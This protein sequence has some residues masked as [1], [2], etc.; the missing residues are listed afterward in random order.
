[1]LR[2]TCFLL[3]AAV[4]GAAAPITFEKGQP[5]L[6]K[7]SFARELQ[8]A[9][10]RANYEARFMH[11]L[12]GT[13]GGPFPLINVLCIGTFELLGTSDSSILCEPLQENV[14]GFNGYQC[15]MTCSD[16]P[17]CRNVWLN[18]DSLESGPFGEIYFACEGDELAD[19]DAT[20]QYL[21]SEGNSC[22]SNILGDGRNFH[23]RYERKRNCLCSAVEL[24]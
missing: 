6:S 7:T 1:M 18:E 19:V 15:R 3:S 8:T 20:M 17:A 13:C 24:H 5:A 12:E 22:N 4:C 16:R 23:I 10:Y 9:K 2:L 21:G 14:E 11:L